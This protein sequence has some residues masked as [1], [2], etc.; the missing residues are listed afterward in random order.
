MAPSAARQQ[1][2]ARVTRVDFNGILTTMHRV[3]NHH[4]IPS[5]HRPVLKIGTTDFADRIGYCL[6]VYFW[7]EDGDPSC[8]EKRR[9][10]F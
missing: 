5:V 2:T 6:Q 3:W 4:L 8:S 1:V 10:H 9:F 7:P